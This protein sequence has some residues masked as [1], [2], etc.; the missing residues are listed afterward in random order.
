MKKSINEYDQ[1]RNMLG[2]IRLIQEDITQG[3]APTQQP[4][5]QQ[6]PAM[7]KPQQTRQT[8]SGDQIRFDDITT[9][10][11]ING[12]VRDE[13]KNNVKTAVGAFIKATGLLMNVVMITVEDEKLNIT[14]DTLKNPSMSAIKS[15]TFDTNE[16]NPYFELVGG[17]LDI[18]EDFSNLIQTIS[19]TFNDPQIGKTAL[20][21]STQGNI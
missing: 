6:Q 8:P 14:S 15:I 11:Y 1:I 20:I 3:Q 21:T 17:K 19:R 16:E 5:P 10:G 18:T 4:M 13:I 2:K 12:D 7:Q 9:V